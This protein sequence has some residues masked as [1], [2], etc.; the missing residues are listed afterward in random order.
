MRFSCANDV[1]FQITN[2]SSMNLS[3]YSNNGGGAPPMMT[4]SDIVSSKLAELKLW[5]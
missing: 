2:K 1:S 5:G 3:K 4:N